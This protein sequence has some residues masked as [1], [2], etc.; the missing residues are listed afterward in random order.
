MGSNPILSAICRMFYIK[1]KFVVFIGGVPNAGK[2]T[3]AAGLAAAVPNTEFIDGD[4]ILSE[5]EE[6]AFKNLSLSEKWQHT[7]KKITSVINQKLALNRNVSIAW[8]L[9]QE[10]YDYVNDY[11]S[12]DA[13]LCCVFLNPDL[14]SLEE[15]RLAR[16]MTTWDRKRGYEM[17]SEGYH[18]QKFLNI[19]LDN[20][21]MLPF[22]TVQHI[23]EGLGIEL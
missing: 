4:F 11:I 19:V 6:E 16:P 14:S 1:M 15:N 7:L 2:S 9:L 22:D 23:K 20:S 18:K 17:Y 12:R 21:R 3:I 10:G 13:R 5:P 8:P